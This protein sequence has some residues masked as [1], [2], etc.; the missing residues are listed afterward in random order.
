MKISE[1]KIFKKELVVMYSLDKQNE[2]VNI[3]PQKGKVR[4]K[5]RIL[6]LLESVG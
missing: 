6:I 3:D 5:M 1:L 2:I 4:R